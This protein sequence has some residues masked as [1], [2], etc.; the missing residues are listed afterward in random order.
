MYACMN[1]KEITITVPDDQNLREKI[2]AVLLGIGYESFMEAEQSLIAYIDEGLFD[3]E[4]LQR[5]LLAFKGKAVVQKIEDL[6]NQNWNAIWESGYE[7]VIVENKC[8]VR[9]PFHEKPA[10]FEYDILI[11]PKMSFGT[12]HHS[13]TYL[14]LQQ[15]LDYDFCGKTVLDMGSGTG[16]LAIMASVK[17]ASVVA[18]IDNDEWAYNNA[19]ENCQLNGIKNIDVIFGDA[20]SIPG[21]VYD[22]VL[23]NINRNILLDDIQHYNRHLQD[24]SVV[25]LSGFYEHDLPAIVD[26][27]AKHGWKLLDYKVLK[28]WVAAKCWARFNK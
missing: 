20:S 26:E 3:P 23:A 11:Q 4:Q 2:M 17:G 18:A 5:T 21:R 14:M 15:M 25:F 12:A 8:I 10:G 9:A 1:Y 13:T 24:G 28:Y 6:E 27:A 19:I 16:V 7:P 22:V